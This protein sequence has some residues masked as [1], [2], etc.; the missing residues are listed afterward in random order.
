V[1]IEQLK[2]AVVAVLEEYTTLTSPK[3]PIQ[4]KTIF[5]VV[6]HRYQLVKHGWEHGKRYFYSVVYVEIKDD[7]V[8]VQ[9]DN[10]EVGIANMLLEHGVPQN[11]IVLGFQPPEYRKY[12]QFNPSI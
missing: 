8:W 12:T 2:Q 3:N 7:L 10:T 5:D 1:E 9:D 6:S 11:Q 4:A